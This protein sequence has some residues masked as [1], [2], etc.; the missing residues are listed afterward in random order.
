MKP[1][2]CDLHIHSCLSPCGDD[3]MT[4]ANIAG[5]ASLNGLEIV[6]LT[7][8]NSSK[9]CPAFFAQAKRVGIIPVAGMELTTAEDIHVI[10]LFR[11]L[12]DAMAFDAYVSAHRTLIPN[13]PE[14]FGQQVIRDENDE[15]VGEEPYLLLNAADL[16]LEDAYRE[17]TKRGGAVY[18]AHI[19]RPSNGIVS[20]LGTFPP[21]PPFTAYELNDASSEGEYR[22]KY[23]VI[24]PLARAVSSDAHN[25][26]SISEAGFSITLD[27][28]PYSSSLVRERLI[29][30]LSGK[31]KSP[32]EQGGNPHG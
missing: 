19:D 15:V 9:N 24:R 3:D 4:P 27:D 25:L 14:I 22:E 8:H 6:A 28:E 17:V 30:Y 20:I 26:W 5:M 32:A 16:S 7:D 12:E 23:P 10:C 2:F 29:D 21:D 13:R 31:D 11:T 18:P 1:Y